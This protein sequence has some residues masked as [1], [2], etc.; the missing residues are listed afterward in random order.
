MSEIKKTP[1]SL[2]ELMKLIRQA[3]SEGAEVKFINAETGEEGVP[4]ELVDMLRK[5]TGHEDDTACTCPAC[6]VGITDSGPDA[7]KALLNV[8]SI[9]AHPQVFAP[10]TFVRYRED[11]K[12]VRDSRALH[13]VVELVNPP[14]IME[15]TSET[16][17]SNTLYRK[18]DVLVAKS[19]KIGGTA[20]FLADSR[21]LE[22]YPD[23]DKLLGKDS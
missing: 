12:Y 3:N 10:G 8:V 9:H 14:R 18:Y 11:V 5:A 6:R 1:K 15:V 7:A 20:I 23:A 4:D 19:S 16:E 22:A 2:D 21:E 17:G 13:C